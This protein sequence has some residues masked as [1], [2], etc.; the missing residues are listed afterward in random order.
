MDKTDKLI[1]SKLQQ[2]ARVSLKELA[3]SVYLSSPATAARLERLEKDGII[4]G[5]GVKLDHK[6]LGYPV[7]AFINLEMQPRQ[8]EEFYPFVKACPNV[9]ECNC[10]T[11]HY[12]ML[13]KVAFPST[14]ELDGFIGKLQNFGN[15]E[16][17]IVFSCAKQ[18]ESVEI[19]IEPDNQD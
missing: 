15:T 14:E 7:V 1:L 13:L 8:K 2:N 3:A 12:S 18:N 19:Q 17:Q 11:G 10:V 5:Y 6:K 16:T 9:I 4:T